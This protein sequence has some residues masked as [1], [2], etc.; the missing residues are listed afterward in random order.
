MLF[1]FT[2]KHYRADMKTLQIFSNWL[3]QQNGWD[4][5]D[6]MALM[7]EKKNEELNKGWGVFWKKKKKN[8]I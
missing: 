2:Q 7:K 5:F 1:E 8:Y 3:Q 6:E 4:K